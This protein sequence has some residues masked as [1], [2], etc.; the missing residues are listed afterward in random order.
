MF[1]VKTYTLKRKQVLPISLQDAWNFF[2]SPAN[3]GAITPPRMH[4]GILSQTGDVNMHE[5]QVIT[6]KITVL[7]LVRM[8]WVTVITRVV[9]HSSFTDVQRQG[10]YSLWEHT[11]SFREINPG[12]E[13]TDE[14]RYA[15]PLGILGRFA[16]W[17]FVRREVNRIFDYRF[18]VLESNPWLP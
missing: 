8:K 11:H 15:L 16:H 17:L 6:Y 9:H 12:I 7:P 5:G 13:M 18:R 10:P 14:V 2:S 3:L 4:F 1:S